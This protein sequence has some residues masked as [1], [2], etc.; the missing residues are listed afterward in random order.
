MKAE[1]IYYPLL[2]R[3]YAERI[4][5]A[6]FFVVHRSTPTS[7]Q[8]TLEMMKAGKN[9]RRKLVIEDMKFL[10]L[11]NTRTTIDVCRLT[12]RNLPVCA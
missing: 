10:R 12:F 2:P 9:R 8:T 6:C 1:G 7:K 3:K 4:G 11:K 5:H